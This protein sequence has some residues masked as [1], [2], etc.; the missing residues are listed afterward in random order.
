MIPREISIYIE[1][2]VNTGKAM[3][4]VAVAMND[5]LAAQLAQSKALNKKWIKKKATKKKPKRRLDNKYSSKLKKE[6]R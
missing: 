5:V 3:D 6:M 1:L 2:V 4:A